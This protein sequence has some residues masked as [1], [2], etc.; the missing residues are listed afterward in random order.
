MSQT[1][2]AHIKEITTSEFESLVIN[3]Q[4]IVLVD[5]H[6]EWCGPCRMLGPILEELAESMKDNTVIHFY[7]MDTDQNPEISQ[8][9]EIR[10]IPSVMIFKAGELTQTFV[11]VQPKSVYQNALLNNVFGK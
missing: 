1:N 8:R 7:K 4:D 10:S 3:T 9:Y 2:S 11:G 6:A 5:F